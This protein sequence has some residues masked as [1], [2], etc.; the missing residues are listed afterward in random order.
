MTLTADIPTSDTNKAED[1]T[2][3]VTFRL[4]PAERD[5]LKDHAHL[6]RISVSALVRHRVLGLPAPK[7]AV[8]TINSQVYTELG[9]V[10]NNLNQL[11]KLAHESGKLGPAQVQPL[12]RVLAELKILLDRAR[13]E[14]LGTGPDQGS[15][16]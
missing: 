16:A 1:Q 2:A 15:A 5:E 7:A 6:A 13:L 11:T 4:T 10:G 9:R 8:P 3:W 14:V 12:A